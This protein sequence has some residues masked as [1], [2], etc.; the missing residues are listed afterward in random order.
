[1]ALELV[2]DMRIGKGHCR[3]YSRQRSG[4]ATLYKPTYQT[5]WHIQ[6]LGAV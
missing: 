4:F 2:R 1:M 5:N 3:R 6:V